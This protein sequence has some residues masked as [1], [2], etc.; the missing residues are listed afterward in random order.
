VSPSNPG[1]AAGFY[2]RNARFLA[3]VAVLHPQEKA[4]AI[5]AL[6]RRSRVPGKAE[7]EQRWAADEAA[8][9]AEARET[10]GHLAHA[11]TVLQGIL[12]RIAGLRIRDLFGHI[13]M[14][15]EH[16][17]VAML[18]VDSAAEAIDS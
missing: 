3:Q 8:W 9:A 15:T 4:A 6:P 17:R 16:V 7:L 2:R 13:E 11:C 18:H 1:T 12:Q 14:E 10:L 5:E